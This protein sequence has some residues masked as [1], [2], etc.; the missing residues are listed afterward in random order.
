M[1]GN[2]RPRYHRAVKLP[3]RAALAAG[4]RDLGPLRPVAV[5]VA[6]VPTIGGVVAIFTASTGAAVEPTVASL[7]AVMAATVAAIALVVLPPPACAFV[8]GCLFG[9]PL[10]AAVAL[11]GV[12][13]GA[14]LARAAVWPRLGAATFAWMQERPRAQAVRAFC[15]PGRRL[16][17]VALL[18]LAAP[19]PFAVQNLLFAAASI[20]ARAVAAGT[21]LGFAPPALLAATA[22]ACVRSWRQHGVLPSPWWPLLALAA[23]AA[24]AAVPARAA[25]RRR[26]A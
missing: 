10:G 18:R 22:G 3:N 7:A 9:A 21:L 23:F 8:A 19:F 25:W 26:P 1:A 17:G 16:R 15:A 4:F 20:P 6:L 11:V 2:A 24:L 12:A 14:A 13:A 5:W